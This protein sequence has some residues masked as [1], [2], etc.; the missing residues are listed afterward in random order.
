MNASEL[1]DHLQQLPLDARVMV[2]WRGL[3]HPVLR[4]RHATGDPPRYN[5]VVVEVQPEH[6]PN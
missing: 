2:E 1:I 3:L 4:L 6:R 5:I